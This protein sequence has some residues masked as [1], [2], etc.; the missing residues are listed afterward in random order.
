MA[1]R[2]HYREARDTLARDLLEESRRTCQDTAKTPIAPE[3]AKRRA[4]EVM[5]RVDR[6]ETE[7]GR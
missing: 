2:R 6:K 3:D 5:Q 1:E 4:T 7:A